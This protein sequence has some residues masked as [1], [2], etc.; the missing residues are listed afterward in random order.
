[1]REPK[2]VDESSASRGVRK[3][4][5]GA[6]LALVI[7]VLCI[8][9]AV[10]TSMATFS[11]L[12]ALTLGASSLGAAVAL[13]MSARNEEIVHDAAGRLDESD[14]ELLID[15]DGTDGWVE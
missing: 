9:V 13:I 2:S 10:A 7:T 4:L 11:G 8:S 12:F 5:G 3:R 14:D 6:V 1:M 15:S